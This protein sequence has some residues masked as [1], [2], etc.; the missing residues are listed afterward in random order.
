MLNGTSILVVEDDHDVLESIRELLEEAG[1]QVTATRNGV[2]GLA[3]LRHMVAAPAAMLV[4]SFMAEMSGSEFLKVCQADPRLARIPAI[5]ISGHS[6]AEFDIPNVRGFVP[7]P[8]D[9]PEL[10]GAL[11][12]LL[13]RD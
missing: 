11:A 1:Y 5:V 6:H 3:A 8:F 4:D 10:L 7:K 2:E 12:R 9:A 13:K